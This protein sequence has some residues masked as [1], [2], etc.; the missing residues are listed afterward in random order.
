MSIAEMERHH[1]ELRTIRR[2]KRLAQAE[3]A[4]MVKTSP[5]VIV[6]VERYG[7]RPQHELRQ[8]IAKALGVSEE[9]IWPGFEEEV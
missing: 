5:T 6:N 4:V 3:L 9:E 2:L 7:Y 1:N 8:R